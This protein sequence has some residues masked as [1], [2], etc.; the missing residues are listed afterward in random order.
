MDM[1]NTIPLKEEDFYR[2]TDWDP[3]NS[4]EDVRALDI[5]LRILRLEL[6]AESKCHSR[7]IMVFSTETVR[8]LMVHIAR[9]Q[10]KND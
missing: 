10:K 7:H 4:K 8:W 2:P 9:L 1:I 6:D 5:V 3:T